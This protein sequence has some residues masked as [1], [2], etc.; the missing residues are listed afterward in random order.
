MPV[1]PPSPI[2]VL[3]CAVSTFVLGGLWYSPVLFARSWQR[4]VGVSDEQ[5]RTTA[6]RTF[7]V[8]GVSALLFSANL[9]FFVGGSSTLAFGAMAGFATGLFMACAITTSYVFGRRPAAL[10]AIDAGYHVAAATLGGTII[11]A[12]GSP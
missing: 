4:L 8:A 11:G 2:A 1:S 5:Q 9:G 3:L 12:F 7:A 10:I 6:Q